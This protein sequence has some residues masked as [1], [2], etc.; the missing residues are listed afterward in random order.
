MFSN[1]IYVV[2]DIFDQIIRCLLPVALQASETTENVHGTFS[3]TVTNLKI[4]IGDINDNK[5]KFY[6]CTVKLCLLNTEATSFIGDINEHSSLGVS[7]TDLNIF[8]RDL[9]QVRLIFS[10][11]N[12]DSR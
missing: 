10:F 4:T 6:Y 9:D 12:L 1:Q 2:L 7:V 5:P 3:N 11:F 8:A